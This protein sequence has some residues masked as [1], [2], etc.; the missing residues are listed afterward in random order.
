MRKFFA[1]IVI[2]CLFV[3]LASCENPANSSSDTYVCSHTWEKATCTE[4]KTCS[5]C[6]ETSGTALGHTTTSGICSRCGKNFSSWEI[7]EFVDEFKQPT[8][9]KYISTT[10]YDGTFSNSATTNSALSACVQVTSDGIAIMLWEYGSQLVKGTFDTNDYS[11]TVLDNNGTKHYLQ[12]TMYKGGI[13]IYIS[14]ANENDLIA[15]LKQP[16]SLNFY[17]KYSKYTT[18]TYLFSIET[19]G[20]SA[21]YSQIN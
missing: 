20:F 21:L 5:K 12:G 19:D 9:E 18:S 13:R 7:G 4:P 16:G 6:G 14:E 10:V 3:C 1:G 8:G 15:L 11:I 17:L 2:L